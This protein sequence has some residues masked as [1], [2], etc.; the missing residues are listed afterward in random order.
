MKTRFGHGTQS[1]VSPKRARTA[2]STEAPPTPPCAISDVFAEA[3]RPDSGALEVPLLSTAQLAARVAFAIADEDDNGDG[4]GGGPSPARASLATYDEWLSRAARIR[5]E[6][7][8][9]L[10][11]PKRNRRAR[12]RDER[13]API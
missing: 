4:C 9:S 8:E 1:E 5:D 10:I 6:A 12:I 11:T 2:F 7:R 3:A 13:R